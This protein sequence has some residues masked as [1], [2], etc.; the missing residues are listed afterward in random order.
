MSNNLKSERC[1]IEIGGKKFSFEIGGM[2]RQANG[3]VLVQVFF[4]TR[5]NMPIIRSFYVKTT[6]NIDVF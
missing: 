6:L 5:G 1:E 4:I 3:T 2:G